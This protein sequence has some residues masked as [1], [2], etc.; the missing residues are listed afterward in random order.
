MVKLG[1]SRAM[2][3]IALF[4]FIALMAIVYQV[5]VLIKTTVN[6]TNIELYGPYEV[7][8]I[9]DGDT[10]K[11]S[12]D[13]EETYI[14]LIGVDTPESV[15]DESYKDNT[16]EGRIAADYMHGLLDGGIVYLEYDSEPADVYGRFLCYVYL[17]DKSTMVNEL[18]LANGYA[19]TMTIEPNV[20]HVER[21]H[22]AEALA[23]KKGAGFWGTGFYTDDGK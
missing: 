9:V 11:A 12:V 14:R 7:D 18:L 21:L 17:D 13:G 5:S 19:R 15:A 22:A 20:K 3:V 6:E 2:Y 23:R 16:E 4:A 10:L 1:K 8:R